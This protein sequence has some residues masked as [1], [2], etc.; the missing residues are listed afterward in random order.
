MRRSIAL[1]FLL[2]TLITNGCKNEPIEPFE[3]SVADF[4]Y[5]MAYSILYRLTNDNL[6]ITYRGELENE[7]DSIIFT[8]TE[9]P[10]NK[11]REL[12]QIRIDSLSAYYSNDCIADGDIKVLL[13]KKN[14]TLKRIQLNNYY[15]HELSPAIEIINKIVPERF[16][17]YYDKNELMDR[18]ENCEDK[19]IIKNWPVE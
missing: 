6:T 19:Q 2:C 13:F 15:H 7:R 14:D 9:L 4:N 17:M 8:T 18:M 11:I 5:S 12:S 3:L 1:T 10:K 16:K